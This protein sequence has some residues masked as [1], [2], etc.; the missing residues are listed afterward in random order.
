V[1]VDRLRSRDLGERVERS[2][3]VR[4][5][6][7]EHELTIEVP[8]ALAATGD[9]ASAFLAATLQLA[10]RRGEDLEIDAPVSRRLLEAC[11]RI[12]L[13]YSGWDRTLRPAAVR[14]PAAIE[15]VPAADGALASFFSRGVDSTY[16][17]VAPRPEPVELLVFCDGLEPRHDETVRAEEVRLAGVVAERIGLPLT[18]ARTN[19]RELTDELLGDWEDYVA[20]ALAFVAHSLAGGIR[21]AVIPSTDD[22]VSLEPCGTSPLLDPLFSTE[23]VAIEH[24]SI[25]LGHAAKVAWIAA[26]RQDLLEQLKVCFREN[27]S[28]NCGRCGKCLITMAELQAAGAL[29]RASLFPGEIDLDAIAAMRVRIR[30]ARLNWLTVCERL[31][32]SDADQRLRAAIEAALERAPREAALSLHG[33]LLKPTSFREHAANS[34][35]AVFGGGT[36]AVPDEHVGLVRVLDEERARH[37][38]SAGWVERGLLV[39]ELGSLHQSDPGD[40][41]PLWIRDDG[42]VVTSSYE[43]ARAAPSARARLRWALAPLAW[44]DVRGFWR[45]AGAVPRRLFHRTHPP[46]PGSATGREFAGFLHPEQGPDR[47]PLY[48][49][50]HP[51]T[52][53]QLLTNWRWEAVDL[54][55]GE[56]VVLGYLDARASLT[57]RLGTSRPHLPW[58][59]RFGQRVRSGAK[60]G[61]S[62]IPRT[63]RRE[64]AGDGGAG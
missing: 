5:R 53:D 52:G 44:R 12:A 37:V 4:W 13:V 1:I 14:A 59:S 20:P 2:A 46:G 17:A 19:L 64:G 50:L 32:E 40:S 9:D 36:S 47:V 10:M 51:I 48:S 55:Y 21:G 8:R 56:P 18:V 54:G 58:A 6:E 3:R 22:H 45:R 42:A 24:D 7:G 57:G 16:C 49:A 63:P 41:I 38:Y 11:E 43:P 33:G 62:A 27:R 60:D 29:E 15:P 28:N 30:K 23:A 35:L 61:A 25:D 34:Q 26:N 31:G 39:G